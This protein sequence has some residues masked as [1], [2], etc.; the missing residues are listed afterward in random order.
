ML[1]S[2][3]VLELDASEKSV[4]G[5]CLEGASREEITQEA[6]HLE[7]IYANVPDHKINLASELPTLT[8][9][10]GVEIGIPQFI[11]CHVLNVVVVYQIR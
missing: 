5:P 10:I 9:R 1:N 11:G 6:P 2:E 7:V 8:R 4:I 3:L